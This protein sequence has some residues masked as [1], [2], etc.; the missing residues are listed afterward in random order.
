MELSKR[1]N[2]IL[3]KVDRC[4]CIADVGTDH[5]YVVV[6]LIKRELCKKAIA[7]D[8]NKGPLEKAKTNIGF[9]GML[10]RVYCRLGGG[11]F[12]IKKGEV[13][14]V[15]VA[16]MGGNLIRDIILADMSKVKLMD[17]LVLQPAQN[18]EVLREFL[19]NNSFEVLDEDIC[20]DDGKYYECF[21]V[22]FNKDVKNVGTYDELDYEISSVLIDKGDSTI[23]NYISSK[24]ESYEKILGYLKDNSE[25]AKERKHDLEEKVKRLKAMIN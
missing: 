7:T 25:S 17:Y 15:I 14:A 19:Y 2:M 5:G 18:P 24:I 12:P 6:E 16:G 3:S 8:I 13:N 11:F 9:E 21:K 23:K 10:D 22:K 20:E 4:E 1:L